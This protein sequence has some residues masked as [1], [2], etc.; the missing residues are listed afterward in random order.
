MKKSIIVTLI[1][2]LVLV[3]DQWLKV[4]VKLNIDY[5]E[6][7]NIMGLSWAQIHFIE[8]PGMAFGLSYG[9]ATG[10]I[11]L[12]VFRIVMVAI[13]IYILRSLIKNKEPLGL[14]IS[15]ALIIAGAMG[16]I[17][18][19]M[20]YG[21]IFSKSVFHGGLAEFMPADG[22]YAPFLQGKVV[23]MFYFPL[24]DT[25]LPDWFPLWGGER[26]QFFRPVFNLADSAIS[27]GVASIILFHRKF[28]KQDKN[29]SKETSTSV[30]PMSEETVSDTM[31]E[32]SK[33]TIEEEE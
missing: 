19:S 33:P 18:D 16:N 5:G 23:D 27:V 8:N 7:F 17:V 28:F 14:L 26:F 6:G 25:T 11:I 30:A 10:K 15:F 22:G 1:I 4:W 21:M 9:G 31:N 24:I 32:I 13:L 2:I 12:T 20:F 3:L 29:K